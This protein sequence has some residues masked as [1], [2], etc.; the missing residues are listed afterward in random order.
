MAVFQ[1][2]GPMTWI[3]AISAFVICIAALLSKAIRIALKVAV[4]VVMVL[5]VAYFLIEAGIINRF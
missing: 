3:V 2:M 1:N 4:I 5:Y